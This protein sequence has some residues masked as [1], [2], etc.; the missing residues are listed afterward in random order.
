MAL[1]E[2]VVGRATLAGLRAAAEACQR[3]ELP[4]SKQVL[5]THGAPPPGRPPLSAIIEQWLN[6][7]QHRDACST[8]GAADAMRPVVR[9]LLDDPVLFQDLLLV[10]RRGHKEFPWHQDFGFW[11]VD[12]PDGIV[13]WIPLDESDAESGAL[14]F[15][16]GSH[17]L[18]ARP[19]V[20][21]HDGQP[22]S[23]DAELGFSPGAFPIFAPAYRAGDA[24]AFS[25]LTFHS[26]PPRLR[27]GERIA[28]SCVFLSATVRWQHARAPNHPVCRRTVDGAKIQERRDG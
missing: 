14:R 3:N 13:L 1:L 15:A 18:G 10:K 24:V 2:D 27:D 17:R 7:H 19:V 23:A 6:P 12:R 4:M 25:P 21:L 26:S 8:G 5:Y 20:D 11:P 16:I 22:Q 9:Q 28:W